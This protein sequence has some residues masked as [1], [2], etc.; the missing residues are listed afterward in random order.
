MTCPVPVCVSW[1]A[2]G[3]DPTD[4]VSYAAFETK[5]LEIMASRAW[6]PD[7]P[8]VLLRVSVLKTLTFRLSLSV[9]L[10]LVLG[11]DFLPN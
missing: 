4:V 7:P 5:M 2:Q 8:E 1:C 3:D 9:T 10:F 6:D 11:Y